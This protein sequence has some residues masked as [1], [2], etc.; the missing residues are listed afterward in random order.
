MDKRFSPTHNHLLLLFDDFQKTSAGDVVNFFRKRL[1]QVG[2]QPA[3]KTGMSRKV[4]DAQQ[5]PQNKT[6]TYLQAKVT[7][8]QRLQTLCLLVDGVHRSI[9]TFL[10]IVFV[11]FWSVKI[12]C[13]NMRVSSVQFR[14][15]YFTLKSSTDQVYSTNSYKAPRYKPRIVGR[16]PCYAKVT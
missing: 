13:F 16:S 6:L 11:S 14:L 3:F 8:Y 10:Y 1:E 15:V 2:L 9:Q 7:A 5:Q 12:F 4:L